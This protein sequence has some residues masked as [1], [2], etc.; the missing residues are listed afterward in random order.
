MIAD[1][2]NRSPTG[3]APVFVRTDPGGA[4]IHLHRTTAGWRIRWGSSTAPF[5]VTLRYLD[6]T[7]GPEPPGW[8]RRVARRIRRIL[9]E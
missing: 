4:E 2:L 1:S 8:R 5:D 9:A 3:R 7:Y 6:A